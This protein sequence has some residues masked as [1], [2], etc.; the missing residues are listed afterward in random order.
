LALPYSLTT[1]DPS[2]DTFTIKGVA[3][4]SVDIETWNRQITCVGFAPSIDRALVI[5]FVTRAHKDGNYW[6][7]L[8][9]ELTAWSYVRKWL[10]AGIPVVGQNFNYDLSY[11]WR[12]Y[13]IA[14]RRA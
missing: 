12:R 3:A 6:R 8:S 4:L 1:Y 2:S 9:E 13:G 7:T 11:L 10:G 14:L 5:P